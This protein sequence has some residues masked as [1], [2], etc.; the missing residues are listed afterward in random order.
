MKTQD[1]TV[2]RICRRDVCFDE[3]SLGKRS[4]KIIEPQLARTK[5]LDNEAILLP[6]ILRDELANYQLDIAQA[7]KLYHA[8]LEDQDLLD[9][10]SAEPYLSQLNGKFE[11]LSC[12]FDE[13]DEQEIVSIDFD[14]IEDG[15]L[16]EDIW[17]RISWLSFSESDMS[18]RFRFSFGME[19]FEDVSEDYQRQVAAANLTDALFPESRILSDNR[20]LI[21]YLSKMLGTEHFDLLE[22]IIYFNA[23]N[24]GAQ[25]HHDA[26]KGHA[27]VVYAQLSGKTF[28]FALSKQQ[29]VEQ[30]KIYLMNKNGKEEFENLLVEQGFS[31]EFLSQLDSEEKIAGKLDDMYCEELAI[32]LNQS[33]LFF[34]QLYTGNF[35][36]V[37]EEGDVMLLP[38]ESI[39]AC[40]WHSVFC[41]SDQAGEALSFAVKLHEV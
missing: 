9:I 25:F 41:L 14:G 18:L 34:K 10:F 6:Q 21:E 22:R 24:G 2:W 26:E 31:K 13:S 35:W 40:A 27:G 16:L 12:R 1:E 8:V 7:K 23:P 32:L 3:I 38:Q 28:W 15:N 4:G 29:L 36:F 39:S 37:A 33:K 11:M 19:G 17:V 20:S 5:W 30:I